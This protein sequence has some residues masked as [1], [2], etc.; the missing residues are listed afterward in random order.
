MGRARRKYYARKHKPIVREL[1][2]PE[3]V[4]YRDG[5]EPPTVVEKE[6]V[7][8]VDQI[9]LIPRWGKSAVHINSLLGRGDNNRDVIQ[10][11]S[12]GRDERYA[13]QAKVS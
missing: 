12:E 4:V 13:T 6:V 10:N 9:F 1:P 2:R 8:L 7:R 11:T 3:R 5:K